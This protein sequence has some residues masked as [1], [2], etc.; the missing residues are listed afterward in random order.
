MRRKLCFVFYLLLFSFVLCAQSSTFYLNGR[1]NPKY[2][3]ELVTLFTFT[4]HF[5]RSVDSTYVENGCFNFAGSEYLYE[6]S[7]VSI[8][9]YPDTVLVAELFLERGEIDVELKQK[10]IIR[11]PFLTNYR[12]YIDSC[13]SLE[14]AINV[15]GETQAFYEAGWE[16]FFAYKFQ[17]KKKYIHDGI[18]RLLFLDE[19]HY[20]DDPYFYK[21]YELLPVRDKERDEV[22]AVYNDRVKLDAQ[23]GLVGRP[24]LDFTL[25]NS[26]DEKKQIADYVGKSDLLYLDFWAS[27]CAP[28]L[29]QEP[30]LKKLYQKY[31][32]DGFEVLGIS[33]DTNK[34]SWLKA[35]EQKG[36]T[37]PELYVGNQASVK[38]LRNLYYMVGIPLGILIDRQGKIAYVVKHWSQL[39]MILEA[40]L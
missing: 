15:K 2:N 5:I 35:I 8:G 11:S 19:A 12:Q 9:N 28:C 10:S 3:G 32:G 21:L 23:K 17:F 4:G 16:R 18:G 14:R 40:H 27:W 29:A 6:R 25:L 34:K 26:A 31:K 24:F 20:R 39:Q 30:H 13:R 7:L 38:E 1:V 37:W 36:L 33:L 22:K